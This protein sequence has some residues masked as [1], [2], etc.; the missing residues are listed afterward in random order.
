MDM[1]AFEQMAINNWKLYSTSTFE[2]VTFA[3]SVFFAIS[4]D[5][6]PLRR[7]SQLFPRS[8]SS[9]NLKSVVLNISTCRL[10]DVVLG[11]AA[12]PVRHR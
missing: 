3:E 5:V 7:D 12:L 2:D 6:F 9:L 10:E 8:N 1:P 4:C 11:L